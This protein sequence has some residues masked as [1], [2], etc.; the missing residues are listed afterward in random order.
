[1]HLLYVTT[2]SS[3]IN[4][5]LVPHIQQLV[6]QGHRVDVACAENQPLAPELRGI[7]QYWPIDF[8]RQAV[9]QQHWRSYRQIKCLVQQQN[10]DVI[11]TH[12]PIASFITRLA[13]RKLPIK[14][15]YTAHGFHF[16][17]HAG[18]RP[19]LLYYPL[20][21]IA[22]RWTDILVTMNTEDYQNAQKL[23]LRQA[24]Q[25]HLSHGVGIDLKQIPQFT[26]TQRS[27]LRLKYGIKP[28]DKL[29][30]FAAEL[31]PRKNQQLLLQALAQ[32]DT[33]FKL[34]L[35]GDGVAKT[36]YQQLAKEL[37]IESRVIFAG[38]QTDV[39]RYLA[40]ADIAVSSARQEGLPV[41]I[42]EALAHNLP[43]VA[44]NI[45]GHRDLIRPGENGNLFTNLPELVQQIQ[46]A[47]ARPPQN[48]AHYLQPF[49]LTNVQDEL[50]QIYEQAFARKY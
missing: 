36:A 23:P 14:I 9:S 27:A 48:N 18:W 12:T 13:C 8:S 21:K 33:H 37:E 31:S 35:L 17:D 29:L 28:T 1:M 22:A 25:V 2:V 40:A 26:A 49:T 5:F 50:K 45:R 3:T 43:V 38:Y 39:H 4:A 15:I 19:W 30:I 16:Y 47:A 6:A 44:S 7:S 10:Y 34:I 20:E 42:M 11:H 24:G 46:K 41:N 32:L